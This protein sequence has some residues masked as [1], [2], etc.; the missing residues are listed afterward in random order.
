MRFA[1]EGPILPSA[2][3]FRFVGFLFDLVDL[4]VVFIL[5][6]F[7]LWCWRCLVRVSAV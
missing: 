6:S 4:F 5:N 3:E 7:G 1:L 2:L